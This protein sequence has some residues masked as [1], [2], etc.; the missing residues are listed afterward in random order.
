MFI[1]IKRNQIYH[2]FKCKTKQL[3]PISL[4][5]GFTVSLRKQV[6]QNNDDNDD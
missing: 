3:S 5:F 6:N 2:A 1:S 4:I